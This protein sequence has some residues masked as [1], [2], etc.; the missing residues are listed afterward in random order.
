[1][2]KVY[3]ES[4]MSETTP[5][6]ELSIPLTDPVE[7]IAA[8]LTPATPRAIEWLAET[9]LTFVHPI[10]FADDASPVFWWSFSIQEVM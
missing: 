5:L 6:E 1:M 9:I 7:R 4:H 3:D 2:A 8:M 10:L